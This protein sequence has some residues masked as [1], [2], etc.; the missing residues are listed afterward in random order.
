MI[1]IPELADQLSHR[2]FPE[3]ANSIRTRS[4]AILKAWR[5]LT[6]IALPHVD[7]L[8]IKQFED[9]IA[10]ILGVVADSLE[11][12]D[13]KKVRAVLKEA[14][15]HGLD[16]FMQDYELGDL[17][18][19]NRILRGV[20]SDEVEQELGRQPAVGESAS[21]HAI[22]DVIFHQGALALVEK[23]KEALR[24]AAEAELKFLSFLSHDLNNNFLV[25]ST[26]LEVIRRQLTQVPELAESVEM[27]RAA[28]NTIRHTTE[29][30][31]RLLKHEQLRRSKAPPRTRMVSL[32]EEVEML[33]KPLVVDAE[34]TGLRLEVAV[35]PEAEVETDPDLL[36]IVL[37]NLITNAV[38]HSGRG[39]VRIDGGRKGDGDDDER[40]RIS[41]AD[42][43]PGISKV[44]LEHI[45]EAFER[46]N[47][48][49]TPGVGLGLAIA[50]QAANLLNAKIEV[51][52]KV[53][54]G[55]TFHLILPMRLSDQQLR[56]RDLGPTGSSGS[57]RGGAMKSS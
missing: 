36:S 3:M 40:C 37:Q 33:V 21:L 30:M 54:V 6:I 1:R 41:I 44:N 4:D 27:V 56:H 50:T 22:I 14:P 24:L 57:L 19:E 12:D 38:K 39:T 47:A 31:R 49:G 42:E 55:S 32:R 25:I 7:E 53:G 23:Q 16:R 5:A 52:S 11:S 46:G 29:G 43:G 20:I 45:F 26:S 8:T 2:P 18:T 51:E 17:F 13:V 10:V 48:L 15:A 35:D 34:A 28:Q 9:S